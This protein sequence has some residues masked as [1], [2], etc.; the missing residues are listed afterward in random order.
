MAKSNAAIII[1]I[2]TRIEPL[3]WDLEAKQIKRKEEK[4][5][6][7]NVQKAKVIS[8]CVYFFV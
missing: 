5:E 4:T 3:R 1:L 6:R 7:K 2:I 8:V